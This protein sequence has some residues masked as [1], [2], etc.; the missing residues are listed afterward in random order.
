VNRPTADCGRLAPCP[1]ARVTIMALICIFVCAAVYGVIN[2][3]NALRYEHQVMLVSDKIKQPY[4]K[5]SLFKP[6][7]L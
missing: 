4:S 6:L 1:L 3:D 7:P 5:C 2:Y